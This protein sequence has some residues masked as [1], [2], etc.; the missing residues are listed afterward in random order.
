MKTR[1]IIT[2]L[3]LVALALAVRSVGLFRGLEDGASFHPDVA[4]QVQ[5]TRNYLE[6]NYLW[7]VGSLA[8]DGYPFGLNHVDEVLLRLAWPAYRALTTFFQPGLVPPDLPPRNT[9]NYAC[10][11]L[12]VLYGMAAWGLLG[13]ALRRA[14]F[15]GGRMLAWMLLAALAPLSSTVTHFATGDVGTDL[16]VMLGLALIMSARS[17][18]PRPWAFFGCG[19]ALG[20]A[21]AC[22]YHGILGLLTPGLFLLM[23]PLAWRTRIKLGSSLAVG[24]MTGFAALTPHLFIRF[25]RTMENIFLNFRYIQRFGA[26]PGFFDRPLTER[27]RISLASNI[28]IVADALGYALILFALL[29]L[30]A[31]A[32]RWFRQRSAAQAWD[33]TLLLMPFAVLLLALTGKPELQPFHFSFLVFPLLLGLSLAEREAK[34]GLRMLLI[35]G[36]LAAGAEYAHRQVYEWSF[37]S[38]EDTR[39]VARRM[40]DGL[41]EPADG[42]ARTV[43]ALTVEKPNLAVFRNMPGRVRLPQAGAWI[44]TPDELVPATPWS[45]STDWIFTDLPA[46]PRESRMLVVD[47]GIPVKRMVVDRGTETNLLLTLHAGSRETEVTW[48]LNG[49]TGRVALGPGA[50]QALALPTGGGTPFT[51]ERATGRRHTLRLDS[52]GAPALIRVGPVPVHAGDSPSLAAKL[53]HAKFLDGAWPINAGR[54][55]LMDRAVLT[56]GRYA[57][58]LDAPG[59]ALPMALRIQDTLTPHPDRARSYPLTWTQDCWR[60]EWNHTPD[61]L[62]AHLSLTGS[63]E[64]STTRSWTWRIRPLTPAPFPTETTMERV[65][66]KQASFLDGRYVVGGVAVPATLPRGATLSVAPLLE[67]SNRGREELEEYALFFHVM[68]HDGH[69]ALARDIPLDHLSPPHAGE[70]LEHRLFQLD[71]PPGSYQLHMGLYHPRTRQ[72]LEP[73]GLSDHAVKRHRVVIGNFTITL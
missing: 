60:V 69:Q 45:F 42:R 7:Y 1:R 24:A 16:F 23:A 43:K 57:F 14:G 58:E 36:Y 30:A 11:I 21:F 59:Q 39:T 62:F 32:S 48:K 53:Q 41:M 50:Q 37:W 22:K 49:R 29:A 71:L 33:T 44:E 8:Y 56:P 25:D 6:G 27:W 19:A 3:L 68:Q 2:V 17:G 34:G 67:A 9:L 46:F 61:H 66:T 55:T 65:W 63:N 35:I 51:F 54:M 12:R 47:P 70:I 28:P 31:A 5:A 72:R 18:T 64:V 15:T 26:D 13:W 4:K 20:A 40:V 73:E 38:R 10:N 52:R